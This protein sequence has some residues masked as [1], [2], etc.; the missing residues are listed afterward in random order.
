MY[1]Y[2][3]KLFYYQHFLCQYKIYFLPLTAQESPKHNFWLIATHE[4]H[5]PV[6]P[7]LIAIECND[8]FVGFRGPKYAIQSI[9]LVFYCIPV[10][11]VEKRE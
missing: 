4:S 9:M 8:N 10:A 1:C 3:Y 11:I 6:V 7:I 5:W 2:I